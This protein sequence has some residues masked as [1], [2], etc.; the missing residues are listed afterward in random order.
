M[1]IGLSNLT[2]LFALYFFGPVYAY[3]VGIIKAVLGGVLF[4]GIMSIFY[5][6]IGIV[7]SVSGM[8]LIK[9]SSKFSIVGVSVCGSGFFQI[10][11]IAV[12]CT[13]LQSQA[14]LYYLS[15]LLIGSV[16]CGL[17]SGILILLIGSRMRLFKEYTHETKNK[18][19]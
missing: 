3:V 9:K 13:L 16:P 1:K 5:G 2:V 7:M 14:P 11:Q 19:E 8:I 18:F 10:G 15:Y 4:S 6:V 17:I 12:A